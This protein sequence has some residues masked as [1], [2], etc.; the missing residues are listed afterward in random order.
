M[1]VGARVR[2]DGLVGGRV[3]RE[4]VEVG[5]LVRVTM[6][7]VGYRGSCVLVAVGVGGLPQARAAR[8]SVVR[9]SGQGFT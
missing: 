5:G 4:R 9:M 8:S 1:P 2:V 6:G 3:R 7:K